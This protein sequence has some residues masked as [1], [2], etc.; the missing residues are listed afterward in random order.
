M[1]LL[2]KEDGRRTERAGLTEKGLFPVRAEHG[3]C[4]EF[5]H[6]YHVSVPY[7]K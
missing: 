1:G 7:R 2:P 4:P 6:I 5:Y 3:I